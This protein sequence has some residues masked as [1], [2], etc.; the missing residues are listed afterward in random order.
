[1]CGCVIVSVLFA[2]VCSLCS[3][4]GYDLVFF[5]LAVLVDFVLCVLGRA[6]FEVCLIA[7]VLFVCFCFF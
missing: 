1:M 7:R 2:F 6:V 4:V 3:V 5:F